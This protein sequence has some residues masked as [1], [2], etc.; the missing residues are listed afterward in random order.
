MRSPPPSHSLSRMR[1]ETMSWTCLSPEHRSVGAWKAHHAHAHHCSHSLSQ[2]PG[3][4]LSCCP[5]VLIT[6]ATVAFCDLLVA[7]QVVLPQGLCACCCLALTCSSLPSSLVTFPSS[8]RTQFKHR[9]LK[10]AFPTAP[11]WV[12]SPS[13]GSSEHLLTIPHSPLE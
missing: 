10:H 9:L 11:A 12:K 13:P 7:P 4:I 5:L 2:D 1:K 3:L 6:P 8:F